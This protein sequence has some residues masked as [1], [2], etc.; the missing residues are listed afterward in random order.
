LSDIKLKE[1]TLT[2]QQ[3]EKEL[4][5]VRKTVQLSDQK[6]KQIQETAKQ[7]EEENKLRIKKLEE[8]N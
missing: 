6:L 1:N 7:K 2:L 4:L 3:K 8:A 5:E